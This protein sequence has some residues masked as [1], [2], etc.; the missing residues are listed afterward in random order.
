[1]KKNVYLLIMF[2]LGMHI[3]QAKPVTPLTARNLATSF[4]KQH[5]TKVP[6]TLTLAYTE[7]SPAGEALYYVFN[8][9]QN[10]GFVIITADDAAHPIIGYSTERQFVVPE[11]NTG[12]GFWMKGRKRQ[13]MAI[14]ASNPEA[15]ADI[16][17]EWAGDFSASKNLTNASQRTSTPNSVSSY[18]VGSYLV[19]SQWNQN[20]Y[21]NKLC[22]GTGSNQAVTG[23]VAT[24][25][26]QIMRF[27]SYPTHGIGS[28]S[29]C[30]CTASPYNM[31]V[32]N[33]T[34]TVNF[35][36]VTYSW[37]SMPLT[38]I[39]NSNVTAIANLMYDC[40]VSVDM[41]YSP[42]GSGAQVLSIDA[43]SDGACAQQSY[44]LHYGYNASTIAGYQRNSGF[45]DAAWINLIET[46]INAGRPVQYAGQ[47][48]SEGDGHTWVCDGYDASNNL[49]MNWGWGGSDDGFFSI[50]NL[51]TT[52]GG[53]D[54]Q[55]DNQVLVGIEPPPTVDAGISTI[56]APYGVLC[57]ATFTPVV[58]LNNYGQNTLTTCN[59]NYQLDGG[60]VM[61]YSWTGSLA[62]GASANISL[63]AITTTVGSHSLTATSNL[64]N[65]TTDGNLTNN[66]S[67]TTFIYATVG[68]AP[69]LV[70]GFEGS[71][72]L[73]TD[74]STSQAATDVPWQVVT[75][76]ASTGS[77][78]V[79]FNNCD[80]DGATDMTG[81]KE[82]LY[83]PTYDFSSAT[84]ATMSFDVGYIP[85]NDGTKLYTDTLAAY[86]STNCGTTWTRIYYKGGIALSTG[87]T[88]TISTSLNC[89]SPTSGQWRTENPSISGVLGN[90]N[91]MFAFENISDWGNWI[92][93]DNINISSVN[94]TGITSLTNKT[95]TN[96]YPNPAHSNLFINTTE[97]TTSV[98]VTDIIG[99]TVISDIRVTPQQTQSIDISS[100]ADGV[101]LV[102][103]NS[104]DSQV[105]VI[106]FIKN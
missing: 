33:G 56:T 91:V 4:Y 100:L 73:P 45:T 34:L 96:V 49:H 11:A 51:L 76:V 29:Y 40:G 86:Y 69:P 38:G 84:S 18:S 59:I 41:N 63:P 80:G 95:G 22:P 31:T 88:F 3:I 105:K 2:V 54:P 94:T 30:D 97:N 19:Q 77:N 26:A 98:S 102:K 53:F 87:P 20:P 81:F 25:M 36:A 65:N 43:P 75:T 1:M 101:Y 47:D 28:H 57:A 6:Q 24:T 67:A 85:A 82:W 71:S 58:T 70:E 39:T 104:S 106:R 8:I 15:T 83:T 37:T 90:N 46:D 55:Q 10:D 62:T 32:N 50:N 61:T 12:I 60:T 16:A 14:K 68:F 13:I 74:W 89:V 48:S 23:C 27:W 44:T 9:N 7:T 42:S 17:R 64:P 103:V 72:S 99:Q 52:N 78:C 5:S 92:Y 21:Y 93:V 79:G 35:A 66:S